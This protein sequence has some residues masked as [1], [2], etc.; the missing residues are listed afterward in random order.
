V[1]APV[2]RRVAEAA[3]NYLGV[4]PRGVE[5]ADVRQL[6]GA[7]DPARAAYEVIR[8]SQ[9]KKPPVQEVAEQAPVG[10]GLVR[11]PDLT[12]LPVREALRKGVALGLAPRVVGT[13]LL[14]HQEPQPGAV[15][16]KGEA[17]VLVFEPAT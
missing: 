9:G 12:G 1:A 16:Q 10:R 3:L 2:F 17:L 15:L 8:R 5:S 7:S 14:A 11:V 6:V 4:T 13:G